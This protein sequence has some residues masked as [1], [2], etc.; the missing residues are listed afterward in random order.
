MANFDDLDPLGQEPSVRLTMLAAGQPVPGDADV[1]ILPG[2]KSTRGDLAFLRA[3]GWDIDLQAHLR[4]GGH[5]LGLCGGFQMLGHSVADPDGI[6]G[7]SGT[8]TGLALLDVATVMQPDKRVALTQAIHCESGA[9]LRG[10]EIHLGETTG[11]DCARPF[12]RIGTRADGAISHDG[13]VQGT[14]LHGIFADDGFRSTW[15]ARFGAARQNA[16]SES[17]DRTLDELA[18]HLETHL[19]DVDG[20]FALAR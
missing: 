15:L 12:A 8:D 6:E 1:V 11:P 13:R 20:F 3:Q 9:P 2:S 5:V 17:V 14:Y 4:R 19:S 16:Y 10:Y 7:L 18:A